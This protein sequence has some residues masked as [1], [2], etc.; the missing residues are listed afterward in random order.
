MKFIAGLVSAA[1]A[2]VVVP[3]LLF[4]APQ[5][6]QA[7]LVGGGLT[8][9]GTIGLNVAKR[10]QQPDPTYTMYVNGENEIRDRSVSYHYTGEFNALD[11]EFE[12]QQREWI[13]L[14]VEPDLQ[15]WY[16]LRYGL[17]PPPRK[18]KPIEE[19]AIDVQAQPAT[20]FAAKPMK[21]A[22]EWSDPEESAP[23]VCFPVEDVAL[24]IAE[25][26]CDRNDA[27]SIVLACPRGTGKT[28]FINA[29]IVRLSH[30]A[31]GNA[32]FAVFN[33][34]HELNKDGS[35]KSFFCGLERDS[36]LYLDSGDPDNAETFL[37]RMTDIVQQSKKH[38]DH[39]LI[40]VC[41]EINNSLIAAGIA[42]QQNTLN[43]AKG[44]STIESQIKV[45]ESLLVTK[46]RSALVLGLITSHSP[47]VKDLGLSTAIQDSVNFVVC[48]RAD[49]LEAIHK[50]L[51]G[52][53][54]IVK[55]PQIREKLAAEFQAWEI[56][57]KRDMEATIALTNIRGGWRLVTLPRY[58]L[59]P[60]QSVHTSAPAIFSQPQKQ[61]EE[62]T[63]SEEDDAGKG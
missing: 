1:A 62:K 35:L 32:Q 61:R 28:S 15:E 21:N 43:T 38:R 56:H 39:P 23:A 25:N 8:A 54:A 40:A 53:S 10:R 19:E 58:D 27:S 48:A 52:N 6:A 59:E 4:F 29:A 51:G 33:G 13:R 45:Q 37:H 3:P 2:T 30:V 5:L 47:F 26:S 20:Q 41:D 9:A 11:I 7:L 34:K 12:M 31:E 18:E 24:T 17:V 50:A 55:N 49:K 42:D 16:L 44:R 22:V 57:P 46:G 36:N 63:E 60:R 14:N